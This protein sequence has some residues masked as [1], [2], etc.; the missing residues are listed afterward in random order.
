MARLITIDCGSLQRYSLQPTL[1]SAAT[2]SRP[3]G[4]EPLA[5]HRLPLLHHQ[6]WQ[7]GDYPTSGENGRTCQGAQCP[8][9]R[10]LL[11]GRTRRAGTDSRHPHRGAEEGDGETH[12]ATEAAVSHHPQGAGPSRPARRAESMP[13]LR[14]HH[15]P[16]TV[17]SEMK[18]LKNVSF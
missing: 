17:T 18:I 8:Q 6:K 4:G 5:L 2:L 12:R 10:H 14:C 9:H 13:M 15:A 3:C 7:S 16:A 11:R 1:P